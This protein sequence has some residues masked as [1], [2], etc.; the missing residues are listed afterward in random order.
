MDIYLGKKKKTEFNLGEEVVQQ[1]TRDLE[2]SF[3]TAILTPFSTAQTK[4]KNRSK[5][6]FMLSEMLAKTE[7]KYRKCL[8]IRKRRGVIA[9]F[10]I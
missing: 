4:K 6:T 8:K 7:N 9:S 3:C 10:C 1:L 2:G 5:R